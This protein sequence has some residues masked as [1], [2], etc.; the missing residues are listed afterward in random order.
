MKV[1]TAAILLLPMIS[2]AQ[3]PSTRGSTLDTTATPITLTEAIR[4]AQQNSPQTVVA[5]GAIQTSSLSVKQAYTAFLPS[6]NVSAGTSH[7]SGE[8][9]DTQGNLVPFTGNPTNYSTGL[10]ASLQLFDA[11]RRFFD[12]RR[13]KADVRAAEAT[14]VTQ[15]YQ[16]ALQVKQQYYNVLAARESQ[17]AAQAQIDQANAQLRAASLRLRA[18]AATASDSLRSV[19]QLGNARLA[20]LTAQNNLG[21]ANATLTRL[22]ASP[23]P[24]T[25]TASDTIDQ[26]VVIPNLAEL[27]PLVE[28]APAIEQRQA[29]LESAKAASKSAKTS[30]FPTVNMNFSRN[31]SGLDPLF[32]NGDKRYAYNQSLN[33]SLQFPLFNNLTREVNVLRASVAEDNAE[34]S[35][36]DARLEA[37]QTL[38]QALGQMTTAQQQVNIQAASVA[39]AVEDLRVQ[40]ARY[41]L[42]ASTLLEVLTS[43]SQL[44]QARTGLIRARYDYRIAKAQ[45]EAL[46]GRDL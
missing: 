36:R 5:R 25:A 22:V 1:A 3:I 21:L 12:I 44:D 31:G 38:V 34:V 10:N 30:Y 9:F 8:R 42:G 4:L 35:L 37:H 28:H 17:S 7:Q 13:S 27:E 15:R 41:E 45:L 14:E 40:R 32:G 19:I 39:A 46:I 2:A 23:R 29:E 33:F 20:L 43:Q 18:G 6:V 16:V 26:R 24:V 11:G